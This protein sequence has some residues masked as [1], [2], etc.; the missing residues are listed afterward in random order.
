MNHTKLKWALCFPGDLLIQHRGVMMLFILTL[1]LL[2]LEELVKLKQL[3]GVLKQ[4]APPRKTWARAFPGDPEP[5]GR[6]SD[7]TE[8]WDGAP[9]AGFDPTF[10]WWM[11][12]LSGVWRTGHKHGLLKSQR[13]GGCSSSNPDRLSQVPHWPHVCDEVGRPRASRC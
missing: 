3:P 7:D 5:R 8:G 4:K 11:L 2:G 1:S 13:R 10:G 6:G 9:R 12:C